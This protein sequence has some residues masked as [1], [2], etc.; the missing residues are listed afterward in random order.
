MSLLEAVTPIRL[1]YPKGTSLPSPPQGSSASV[2]RL[3][4]L[5]SE[6]L[7]E[8]TDPRSLSSSQSDVP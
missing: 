2:G 1:V 5:N 8:R 3:R 6:F 7:G 4:G